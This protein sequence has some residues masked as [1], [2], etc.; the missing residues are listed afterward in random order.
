MDQTGHFRT[1]RNPGDV[2]GDLFGLGENS[3]DVGIYFNEQNPD[4][5]ELRHTLDLDTLGTSGSGMFV[6]ESNNVSGFMQPQMYPA[7]SSAMMNQPMRYTA[8]P[9]PPPNGGMNYSGFSMYSDQMRMA[10]ST[11]LQNVSISGSDYANTVSSQAKRE[12]GRGDKS[13]LSV[14]KKES[15]SKVVSKGS[16]A[17]AK[18]TKRKKQAEKR[19]KEDVAGSQNQSLQYPLPYSIDGGVPYTNPHGSYYHYP[20]MNQSGDVRM[21]NQNITASENQMKQQGPQKVDL[22]FYVR[23]TLGQLNRIMAMLDTPTR[24]TISDSLS[25]LAVTKMKMKSS[26]SKSSKKTPRNQDVDQ[27]LIDRSVCQL[28]YNTREYPTA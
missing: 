15:K 23:S 12:D 3:Y 4:L 2:Y 18:N 10:E 9:P 20:L 27:N 13:R 24:K 11:N 17:A 19:K 5:S 6:N 26:N 16:K 1:G 22:A 25:R 28:L 7:Q 14:K 21:K 8:V